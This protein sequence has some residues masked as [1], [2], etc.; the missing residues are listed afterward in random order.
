MSIL[1]VATVASSSVIRMFRFS[2]PTI[3]VTL[4][5]GSALISR[6]NFCS[7]LAVAAL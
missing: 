1:A 7:S 6:V 2:L 3:T 4:S 5:V